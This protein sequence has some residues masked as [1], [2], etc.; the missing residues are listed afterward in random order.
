MS[1]IKLLCLTINRGPAISEYVQNYKT[2]VL[3]FRRIKTFRLLYSVISKIVLW[4]LTNEL[5]KNSGYL[6]QGSV[7]AYRA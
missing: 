2:C 1:F 6:M 7:T 5:K 3:F 4:K